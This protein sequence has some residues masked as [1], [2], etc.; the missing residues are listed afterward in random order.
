VALGQLEKVVFGPVD[1]EVVGGIMLGQEVRSTSALGP[2]PLHGHLLEGVGNR[3]H[4]AGPLPLK[5]RPHC[6]KGGHSCHVCGLG[7]DLF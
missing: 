5:P 7:Q 2:H 4:K 3:G 1:K 6:L